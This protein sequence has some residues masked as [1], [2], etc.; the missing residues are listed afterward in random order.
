MKRIKNGTI[1]RVFL[2][3]IGAGFLANSIILL[4]ISNF[5][6]GVL[7]EFLLGVVLFSGGIF[8]EWI[9]LKAPVWLKLVCA[10]LAVS[11]CAAGVFLVGNG[12]ND[13]ADYDEDVIIVLGAGVNGTK[14]GNNLKRRL[15]AAFAYYEKNN[16]VIIVVS[17]GKGPQEDVTE[18][19]AME[20]YLLKKGVSK[21]K[22]LKEEKSSSTYENFLFSKKILD[23]K[24]EKGFSAC[25]VTNDFH[26][27]RALGIAKKAGFEKINHIHSSTNKFTVISNTLRECLAVA[28]FAV[29]GR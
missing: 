1:F 20:E 21:A 19:F 24:L 28:K 26:V 11:V 3:I 2:C 8:F 12:M 22:I 16:D 4:F 7:L 9:S 5:H 23:E 18:A 6:M 14:V 27:F 17:G 13:T 15:D 25:F 10:A 29:L